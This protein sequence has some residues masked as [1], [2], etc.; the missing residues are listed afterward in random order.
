VI[1]GTAVGAIATMLT[2]REPGTL[3]GVFIVAG[4]VGAGLAV[5]PAA[6]RMILPA[7][8]LCYLAAALVTGF[9]TDHADITSLTTLAVHAT[10]WIAN[11][12]FA[13]ALATIA[14]IVIVTVR[15]YLRRR[16][17]RGAGPGW[18]APVPGRGQG[19]G[20]PTDLG[21]TSVGRDERTGA[22]GPTRRPQPP[23]PVPQA[24]VPQAPVPQAPG[25]QAPGSWPP[26]AQPSTGPGRPAP[27]PPRGPGAL[28][29]GSGSGP[30]GTGTLALGRH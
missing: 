15:W 28:T 22:T 23:T 3:L 8:V 13:M 26:G 9:I 27:Q 18:T 11:G 5:R 1:A 29:S 2:G 21:W 6:G 24:P 30:S 17:R 7:P 14:A 16:A 19:A 10:Q 12:F 4:T 20:E 25:Q